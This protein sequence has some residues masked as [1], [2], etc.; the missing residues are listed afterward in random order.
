MRRT[1][2]QARE[3]RR[4]H[5]R[6]GARRERRWHA[7]GRLL[8]TCA[9]GTSTRG[10]PVRLRA[11]ADRLHGDESAYVGHLARTRS[12]AVAPPHLPLERRSRRERVR[13]GGDV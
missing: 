10:R 6:D 13:R 5:P 1:T 3:R 7:G 12:I 4:R 8:H 9:D 2:T 11:V